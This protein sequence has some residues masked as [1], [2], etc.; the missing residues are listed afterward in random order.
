MIQ[1]IPPE[2]LQE[3]P[4]SSHPPRPLSNEIPPRPPFFKGGTEGGF[5]RSVTSP[6]SRLLKKAQVQ[7]GGRVPIRRTGACE[8]YFVRMPQHGETEPTPQMGL[9]YPSGGW[10]GSRVLSGRGCG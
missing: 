6:T 3:L 8:A 1:V 9:G 7:G 2:E 5:I 10:V 4:Q